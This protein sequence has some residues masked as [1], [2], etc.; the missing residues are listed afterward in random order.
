M[1]NLKLIWIALFAI[2]YSNAQQTDLKTTKKVGDA[3]HFNTLVDIDATDVKS[4]GN[5]GTCWSF[6]TSSF[7]ESEILR[8]TGKKV[9]VSEMYTVRNMYDDKD[10]D[11]VMRQGK[12]QFGEGGLAHDVINS[13][14]DNGLVTEETFS[15]V[16]VNGIYN[17]SKIVN[18][19]KPILD[20]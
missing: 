12:T 3:Y 6:S 9:D 19:I 1:K 11:Y 4:Q 8:K 10:W 16:K 5:T 15:G 7:I 17:H 2:I 18:E 14:R 13:I 20:D